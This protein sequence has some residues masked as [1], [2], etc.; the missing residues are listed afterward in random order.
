MATSPETFNQVKNILRKLDR[1]IDEIRTRRSAPAPAP[2]KAP[3][4]IPS[5]GAIGTTANPAP[6]RAKPL[7][8]APGAGF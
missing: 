1:S 5:V 4:G 6:G 3:Q 8:R 7:G 2:A